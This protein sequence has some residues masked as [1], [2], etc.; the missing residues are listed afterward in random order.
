MHPAILT[1]IALVKLIESD[2]WQI[3]VGMN[4]R[5]TASVAAQQHRREGNSAVF[6]VETVF[7]VDAALF[8]VVD[9]EGES[10]VS[11]ESREEF[12]LSV[13]IG[14]NSRHVGCV[15]TALP[16]GVDG[17]GITQQRV[18][19]LFECQNHQSLVSPDVIVLTRIFV[20]LLNDVENAFADQKDFLVIAHDDFDY[21]NQF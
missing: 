20:D 13:E 3:L 17:S 7:G 9:D 12:A 4:D 18:F 16:E 1:Q 21:W 14:E 2:M 11:R 8:Q 5:T 19:A 10:L 15:A 6:M